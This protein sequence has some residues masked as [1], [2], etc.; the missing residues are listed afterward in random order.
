MAIKTKFESL[1]SLRNSSIE[2]YYIKTVSADVTHP[3]QAKQSYRDIF[4]VF[5]PVS[6]FIF[7]FI[8]SGFFYIVFLLGMYSSKSKSFS[9]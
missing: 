6:L 8:K 4:A 3:L 1:N 5:Y 7:Y 2:C 9:I